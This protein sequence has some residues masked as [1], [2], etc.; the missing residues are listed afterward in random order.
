LFSSAAGWVVDSGRKRNTTESR[1]AFCPKYLSLRVRVRLW[2]WVQFSILNQPPEGKVSGFLSRPV[3][4][5]PGCFSMKWAGRMKLP[6]ANS[7]F[8]SR[9]GVLKTTVTVLPLSEPSTLSIWS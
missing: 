7:D 5:P 2:P 1:L 9:K 8:Q 3:F 4:Q 6:E